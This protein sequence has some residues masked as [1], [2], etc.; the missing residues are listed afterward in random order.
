VRYERRTAR[1]LPLA[2]ERVPDLPVV[3]GGTFD[4]PDWS[5]VD[6]HVFT[7]SAVRWMAYLPGVRLHEKRWLD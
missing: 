5:G 6:R 7:R 2:F 3:T 1:T 4:D